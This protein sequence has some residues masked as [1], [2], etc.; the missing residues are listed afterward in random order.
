MVSLL[1]VLEPPLLTPLAPLLPATIHTR[2][3]TPCSSTVTNRKGAATTRRATTAAKW[4]A[5]TN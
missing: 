3:A 4:T 2:T 1:L 5:T